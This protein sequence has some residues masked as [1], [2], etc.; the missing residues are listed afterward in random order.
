MNIGDRICW[1]AGLPNE[2]RFDK[3]AA[4][5]IHPING[6][7]M[8]VITETDLRLL[9][10]MFSVIDH[11]QHRIPLTENSASDYVKGLIS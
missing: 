1:K 3:I 8:C 11:R 4:M 9:R 10:S 5:V 7:V 2:L 6:T